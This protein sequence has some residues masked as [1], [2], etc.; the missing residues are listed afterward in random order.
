MP[1]REVNLLTLTGG[2]RVKARVQHPKLHRDNTKLRNWF[3]RYWGDEFQANRSTKAVRK[4]YI[5]GPSKGENAI[6]EKAALLIRDRE[7]AKINAPTVKAAMAKGQ[8]LFQEVAKMY[9]ESHVDRRGKLAFPTRITTK[10]LLDN[11]ILRQWGKRRLADIEAKEVEDWLFSLKRN[12]GDPVSW[13]T[14]KNVRKTMSAVYHKAEE[15]GFW[16]EGRRNPLVKVDIGKKAYRNP[17]QILTWQQTAAVLARME[18]PNRLVTETCVATSTR[19]SEVTGLMIKHFDSAAK[20]IRIEQR[21]FHGDI[22]EPKTEGSKRV[23]ALGNLAERYVDWIAK[24]ERRGPD[25]WIFPQLSDHSKPLWDSGVRA[26]IHKAAEDASCDFPG[27]GPHSFRRANITWRQE[28]GGTAIEA[29]KIAG[30]GEIDMTGDYTFVGLDRQDTLTRAIQERL[31][32]AAPKDD[33]PD[34]H[35]AQRAHLARAR[36]AKQEKRQKPKVIEIRR[37]EPA[38]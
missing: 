6:T 37:K 3:F 35:P 1:R 10:W 13:W 34:S 30:H 28:V 14:M 38:A 29:S 26:A 2:V 19:I 18:D 31:A 33:G 15:W 32:Q 17:R 20:T 24:L 25:D 11:Y 4:K 5:C 12:D 16:E 27:L 7:L 22:D 36:K 9:I 21:N 23:L 8:V